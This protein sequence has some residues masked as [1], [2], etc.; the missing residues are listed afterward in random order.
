V[1]F[2]GARLAVM[3]G[4]EEI[5]RTPATP[6]AISNPQQSSPSEITDRPRNLRQMLFTGELLPRQRPRN[7]CM[8][9]FNVLIA[10]SASARVS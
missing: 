3:I 6:A 2:G 9:G 4:L 8:Q 5:A 10:D 7:Y 1:P